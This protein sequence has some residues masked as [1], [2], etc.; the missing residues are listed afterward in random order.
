[1]ISTSNTKLLKI[2][3]SAV[4]TRQRLSPPI[5][6]IVHLRLDD[7][8]AAGLVADQVSGVDDHVNVLVIE[9]DRVCGSALLPTFKMA[10]V[11]NTE[12]MLM[13]A[14]SCA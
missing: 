7:Q 1:M 10:F 13:I 9:A 4:F 11:S 12:M 2:T 5:D 14:G 3:V 6:Q 8:I